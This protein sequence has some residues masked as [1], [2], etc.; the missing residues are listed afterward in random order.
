MESI[1]R[2]RQGELTKEK[3]FKNAVRLIKQKG[4]N[5]VTVSE[6][7]KESGVS[8]GGFYVHYKSKEDIVRESYYINMNDYINDRFSKLNKKTLSIKDKIKIFLNLE[9]EFAEYIGYELTCLSYVMNLNECTKGESKHFEKREFSSIL[10]ECILEAKE[11]DVLKEDLS[12]DE[13]FLFIESGIR[14]F[15]ASWCFSNNKFNISLLGKKYIDT[16][17]ESI[18]I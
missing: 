2:K 10:K 9:L 13:A 11:Q 3:I 12:I 17:I 8:K 18:L 14:G 7:C 15:M 6:I 1:P 4:Y 5:D 16:I